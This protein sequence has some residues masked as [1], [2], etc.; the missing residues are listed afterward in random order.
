[1]W[2]IEKKRKRSAA[3]NPGDKK[4]KKEPANK[5]SKVKKTKQKASSSVERRR[6]SVTD[7]IEM[8]RQA[9]KRELENTKA[10]LLDELS[11]LN[12]KI[13]R[14]LQRYQHREKLDAMERRNE[15][16]DELDNIQYG[17]LMN[18]FEKLVAPYYNSVRYIDLEPKELLSGNK[19]TI[20]KVHPKNDYLA[21][22]ALS[23]VETTAV[24]E[25][26][27][28]T[29]KSVVLQ[30]EAVSGELKE[31]QL[32]QQLQCALQESNNSLMRVHM[33]NCDMCLTCQQPTVI[34]GAGAIMGCTKCKQTH[35]FIQ[36]TSS[37]IAYGEEVEFTSFSYRREN[38]FQEWLNCF[39]AKESTEVPE[40][41]IE[42][43]R[44]KCAQLG[45]TNVQSIQMSNVREALKLLGLSKYYENQQQIT[46]RLSGRPA[47]TMT[48]QQEEQVRCMFSAIIPFFE[49]HKPSNRRNFLSYAY[50]LYK[51]CELM[52]WTQFLPCFT[53]LKGYDK[54]KKQDM[55]FEKI[56]KDLDWEFIPSVDEEDSVG[57]SVLSKKAFEKLSKDPDWE[58]VPSVMEEDA[59]QQQAD[60]IDDDK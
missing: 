51:F 36:A 28:D 26:V 11:V 44:D 4:S 22:A 48:P 6:M 23:S 50:C 57:T 58:F 18:R 14:L 27:K 25:L 30:D 35:T 3:L 10:Q 40:A 16:M 29:N 34:M 12:D 47:P 55:I 32:Q 60:F 46:T 43:V 20:I 15:I 52:G 37:R 19:T 5:K 38:H 2:L 21:V 17:Y 45:L 13:P 42:Q 41:I 33:S 53:L 39:Q 1:M 54:L 7:Y 24:P 8:K 31:K 49:K 9:Y 59:G 56:C